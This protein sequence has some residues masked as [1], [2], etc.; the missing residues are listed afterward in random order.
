MGT[1]FTSTSSFSPSSSNSSCVSVTSAGCLH[2]V[3]GMYLYNLPRQSGASL[4]FRVDHLGTDNLPLSSFL[5]KTCSFSLS[6]H[7]SPVV[8]HQRV[9]LCEMIASVDMPM[10]VG[11]KI[12]NLACLDSF[13]HCSLLYVQRINYNPS[14]LYPEILL[15]NTSNS[16]GGFFRNCNIQDDITCQ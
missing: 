8:F 14:I 16:F 9:G 3:V 10:W 6:S 15:F 7:Q 2:T 4:L 11:K 5:E 12:I 13:L 1:V